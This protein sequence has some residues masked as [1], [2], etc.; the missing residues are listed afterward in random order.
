MAGQHASGVA[1]M[2]GLPPML[3]KPGGAVPATGEDI[4]L[5]IRTIKERYGFTVTTEYARDF[6]AFVNEVTGEPRE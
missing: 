6:I 5:V 1:P 2:T 3:R 4:A